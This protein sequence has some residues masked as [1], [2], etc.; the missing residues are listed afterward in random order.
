MYDNWQKKKINISNPFQSKAYDEIN[1]LVF[2]DRERKCITL[3]DG[4]KLIEFVS[5]SYLGLHLD[6]RIIHAST[7]NINRIGITFS[8]ARTRV[9]AESFL[10]LEELLQKI[11]C[12]GYPII[13]STLHLG[14]LG[15][16][17]ILGSGE[18]PSFP[19]RDNGFHF[20][21]DKKVHSS[22][23]VHRALM[24]QFGSVSMVGFNNQNRI[25]E[26]FNQAKVEGKTPVAIADSIG[27]MG[28]VAPIRHLLNLAEQYDGYIYLDDAHGTSVYGTHG[29]GYALQQL[30]EVFHRRLI[31]ASSLAKGFGAVAGAIVLPT[32]EDAE[33]LKKFAPTY[34]F[35]GPP[36]LMLIDAA[37]ESAK[38]HLTDEIYSLQNKLYEN[39]NYFDM[40]LFDRIV[41][42]KT[43]SPIR[44]VFIGDEFKVIECAKELQQR[45]FAVTAAMYPT[46]ARGQ[47][48][49]RIAL[50]AMHEKKQIFELCESIKEVVP[51]YSKKE[52]A[53]F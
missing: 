50:S 36:A 52:S 38:I 29:C 26:A 21:L 51:Y 35:G 17:P 23:Q 9:V 45:G 46:V 5:C 8:A 42:N 7:K 22:I 12:N 14:H 10:I 16:I 19:A 6:P 39:I 33:M 18:L 28:G 15:M 43:H 24:Q 49:L 30:N 32:K 37:I 53:I 31:L 47:G 11:F 13:F 1:E 2:R 41:N 27:S 25:E 34:V 40:L 3:V 44:G 4:T 48:I 20:V